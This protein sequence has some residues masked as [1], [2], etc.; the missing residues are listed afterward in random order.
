[1]TFF[2]KSSSLPITILSGFCAS[3]TA[4]PSLRNSGFIPIPNRSLFHPL[5]LIIIGKTTS[6]VVLGTTVD[7]TMIVCLSALFLSALPILDEADLM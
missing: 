5:F 4:Q 2:D 3:L 7:L 6:S 1:M